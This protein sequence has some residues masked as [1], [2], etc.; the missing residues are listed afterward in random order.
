MKQPVSHIE[1]VALQFVVV[2]GE[3]VHS[4]HEVA[5]NGSIRE[6]RTIE[7]QG[8]ITLLAHLRRRLE[9][10]LNRLPFLLTEFAYW[11]RQITEVTRV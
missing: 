6:E 5:H 1:V 8:N 9:F 11:Y 7:E 3:R 2:G 4:D 10:S